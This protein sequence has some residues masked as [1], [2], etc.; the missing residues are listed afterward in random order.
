MRLK[1]VSKAGRASLVIHHRV[2]LVPESS[3]CLQMILGFYHYRRALSFSTLR[4]ISQHWQETLW[5]SAIR[6]HKLMTC[7]QQTLKY[8]LKK[9]VSDTR[10]Y[11]YLDCMIH[12][13]GS[14]EMSVSV[15]LVQTQIFCGGP[16][17]ASQLF[18][19]CYCLF[20]SGFLILSIMVSS[21]VFKVSPM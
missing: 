5:S 21:L 15:T 8:L 18:V 20:F 12:Y 10:E 2:V 4:W 11:S 19:G 7:L 6:P 16:V 14:K 13:T 9:Y 17:E 3:R 1:T